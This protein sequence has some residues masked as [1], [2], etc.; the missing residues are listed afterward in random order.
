MKSSVCRL[1]SPPLNGS[2]TA[3]LSTALASVHA[4]PS[5]ETCTTYVCAYACSHTR[6]T[7]SKATGAP[8][9]TWMYW[10]SSKE[11][12][13]RVFGSPS[14]TLPGW[15]AGSSTEEEVAVLCRARSVP[16]EALSNTDRVHS[17]E[18][19]PVARVRH[20]TRT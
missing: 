15:S 18:P 13:H 19:Q 10:S 16:G 9:S 4:E 11:E 6:S 2:G 14:V 5:A 7:R 17:D 1:E 12:D 3:A 8:R 20:R